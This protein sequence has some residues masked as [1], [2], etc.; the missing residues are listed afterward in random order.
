[1]SAS[2]LTALSELDALTVGLVVL[3]LLIALLLGLAAAP[4]GAMATRQLRR[5]IDEVRQIEPA[6]PGHAARVRSTSLRRSERAGPFAPLGRLITMLV[7]RAET[8]RDRL[9]R[10]G[11]SL[12][13]GDLAVGAILAGLAT[14]TGLHLG[15]GFSL[16]V[17]AC[18]GIIASTGLP[19]LLISARIGRRTR[20]LVALLPD[21]IDL[22][23]R[24]V[25]S[26]LPVTEALHAIGQEL[27][28]P[29]GGAF[30]E[31]TGNLTL[32]MTLEEALWTVAR[33]LQVPEFKFFVISVSIQQET[34][35]N[36]AE[37]L[38]NLSQ[39]IRRRQQVKLKIKA[40]SSE[41]RASAMIIGSLPFIMS[42]VIY[43]INPSYIMQLFIDPRG[44]LLVGAGLTSMSLGIAVITKMVRFEI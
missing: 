19:H 8:L 29:V 23:V 14:T 36:L 34:G 10:A 33:R 28:E 21:A 38:Q 3:A 40:M 15:L 11:L 42:I 6:I 32:G 16:G 1:M 12:G 25:K 31:V 7:P 39:M 37:I 18:A 9:A 22:I 4:S 26:G 35:G 2:G 30:R 24:G 13:V 27:A 5:R 20:T 17:S 43:V 44:W 41:A